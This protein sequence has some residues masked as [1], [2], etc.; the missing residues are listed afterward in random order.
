MKKHL[1]VLVILAS[2]MASAKQTSINIWTS[3]DKLSPGGFACFTQCE[4]DGV[5]K[6][7]TECETKYRGILSGGSMAKTAASRSG[8]IAHGTCVLELPGQ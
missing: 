1:I 2:S 8:F 6:L 5:D 3:I 4:Q 7:K